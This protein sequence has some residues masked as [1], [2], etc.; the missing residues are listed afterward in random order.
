M[1]FRL[2]GDECEGVWIHNK[3]EGIVV[4]RAPGKE[5]RQTEWKNDQLIKDLGPY[6]EGAKID[7]PQP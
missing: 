5:P 3:R 1:M 6:V 2:E 7:G 4:L